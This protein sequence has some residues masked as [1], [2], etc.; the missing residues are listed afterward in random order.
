MVGLFENPL[1]WV[2]EHPIY[3]CAFAFLL[4][5]IY[6]RMQ[7]FPAKGPKIKALTSVADFKST[8]TST[9]VLY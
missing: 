5:Q 9:K 7:P 8:L 1:A 6:K 3:A 2:S 4:L